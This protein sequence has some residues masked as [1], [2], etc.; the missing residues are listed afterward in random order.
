MLEREFV[1]ISF[2]YFIPLPL[3]CYGFSNY[4][5]KAE[6]KLL[7]L[8]FIVLFDAGL[9]WFLV[10]SNIR[11]AELPLISKRKY[12][13]RIS[14]DSADSGHHR[15]FWYKQNKGNG[16]K[17]FSSWDEDNRDE[18]LKTYIDLVKEMRKTNSTIEYGTHSVKIC[19]KDGCSE[20]SR[21][22]DS[23]REKIVSEE[24]NYAKTQAKEEFELIKNIR[25]VFRPQPKL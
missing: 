2:I 15:L 18:V 12:M 23:S 1:Y 3:C 8:V 13:L 14:S 5:L 10:R 9:A 17:G 19:N 24:S 6:M 20:V 4:I 11:R 21:V 22:Y 25:D 16:K 7:Y